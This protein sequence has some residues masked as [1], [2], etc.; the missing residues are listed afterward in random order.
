MEQQETVQAGHVLF[1]YIFV[2]I[3]STTQNLHDR[4]IM[5]ILK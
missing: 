1:H 3:K 5:E 4:T 2:N